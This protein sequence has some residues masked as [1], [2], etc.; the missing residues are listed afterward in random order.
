MNQTNEYAKGLRFDVQASNIETVDGTI[1]MKDEV[2]FENL[3]IGAPEADVIGIDAFGRAHRQPAA[4]GPSGDVS[5]SIS[6]SVDGQIAIFD[7][8]TGK[9]IKNSSIKADNGEINFTGAGQIVIKASSYGQKDLSTSRITNCIGTSNFIGQTCAYV[10]GGEFNTNGQIIGNKTKI[11]LMLYDLTDPNRYF[12]VYQKLDAIPGTVYGI[13]TDFD[14]VYAFRDDISAIEYYNT[15]I[16]K[17]G[18]NLEIE[19]GIIDFT[20]TNNGRSKIEGTSFGFKDQSNGRT[21]HNI[22]TVD[23]DTRTAFGLCCGGFYDDDGLIT[24]NESRV[25]A[26]LYDTSAT[27]QPAIGDNFVRFVKKTDAVPGSVYDPRTGDMNLIYQINPDGVDYGDKLTIK[28][29]SNLIIE[30]PPAFGTGTRILTLDGSGVVSERD[31]STNPWYDQPLDIGSN[32][33]FGT[34][35]STNITSTNITSQGNNDFQNS[36]TL[37]N[38]ATL[39]DFQNSTT[40]FNNATLVDFSG[41]NVVG[42]PGGGD[43]SS[44]VATVVDN[45][46]CRFDG[47]TGKLIQN[48]PTGVA[49]L[50]DA[51]NL[52]VTTITTNTITLDPAGTLNARNVNNFDGSFTDFTNATLTCSNTIINST[53]NNPTGSKVLTLNASNVLTQRDVSTNP[54]YNQPLDSGSNVLFDIVQV[55]QLINPLTLKIVVVGGFDVLVGDIQ[56]NSG[57]ITSGNNITISGQFNGNDIDVDDVLTLNTTSQG[58]NK[59]QNSTTQFNNATLVDYNGS[60]VNFQNMTISGLNTDD[61]NRKYITLDSLDQF[62]QTTITPLRGAIF[63][64]T[65]FN[66]SIPT[67]N[68]FFPINSTSWQPNA[69]V[70]INSNLINSFQ[71]GIFSNQ[72]GFCSVS[73]S[74]SF[75]GIGPPNNIYQ[76]AIFRNGVQLDCAT[77]YGS[78]TDATLILSTSMQCISEYTLNDLFDIRVNRISGSNNLDIEYATLSLHRI[79]D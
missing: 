41:A 32:V 30:S 61:T 69:A 1:F 57:N 70:N 62:V 8:T 42:L 66:V 51:G 77:Q 36:T 60:N 20:N 48:V 74:V 22:G 26:M 40:L 37:F 12:K 58:T 45:Q 54:W 9:I 25:Y 3:P 55:N 65:L 38:N 18:N 64:S 72:P 39:V 63:L 19:D 68:T 73:A 4:V 79:S 2:V 52:D 49:T 44:S 17:S 59:F 29:A 78:V 33:N 71:L 7:G 67:N 11:F 6:S 14:L 47:T 43:V 27:S 10:N 21:A 50:S 34:I 75:K 35:N 13:V 24:A 16:L 28:P 46:L 56:L 15:L 23:G 53:A 76:I 5:S 31:I